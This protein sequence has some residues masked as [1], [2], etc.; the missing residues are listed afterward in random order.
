MPTHAGIAVDRLI[1]EACPSAGSSNVN[2]A[3]VAH[4]TEAIL[5]ALIACRGTDLHIERG[6]VRDRLR[7]RINGAMCEI[8]AVPHPVLV[9]VKKRIQLIASMWLGEEPRIP[10]EARIERTFSGVQYHLWIGTLPTMWGEKLVLRVS[11]SA[12][13]FLSV[14]E[15]GLDDRD[16]DSMARWLDFSYGIVIVTGATGCGGTTTLL[17]MAN[18]AAISGKRVLSLQRV[19]E[20]AAPNVTQLRVA[21]KEG[22]TSGSMLDRLERETLDLVVIDTHCSVEEMQ[23]IAELARSSTL[24]LLRM[25][26]VSPLSTLERLQ[27][28]GLDDQTISSVVKGIVCTRLV[29]KLC[30]NCK[31]QMNV[32]DWP[33]EYNK[34]TELCGLVKYAVPGPLSCCIPVGCEHCLG[35]GYYGRTSLNDY[36]ELTPNMA[37]AILKEKSLPERKKLVSAGNPDSVVAKAIRKIFN[38]LTT[39]KEVARALGQYAWYLPDATT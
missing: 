10:R 17:A 25:R 21:P 4:L 22:L 3:H 13:N 31:V 39:E 1:L 6:K 16:F 30:E 29:R 36:L 11:E 28:M 5:S 18:E 33:E 24:F 2:D 7:F 20:F 14:D 26:A 8:S 38:G 15:L 37:E 32:E 23:Q 9:F 35:T 19:V 27:G 12:Y 34:L